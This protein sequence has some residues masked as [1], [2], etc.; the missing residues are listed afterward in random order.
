MQRGRGA[1]GISQVNP[2]NSDA[3][4]LL[5]CSI[6]MESFDDNQHQPK[7]LP[8]HHTFCKIC[9]LN[10]TAQ[11]VVACPTCRERIS[12]PCPPPEGVLRL[13]TNFYITQMKDL[14]SDKSKARVK[15]C[16][17]HQN[18][19]L[20]FFCRSC[21]VVIC[22]EC[23]NTD[24]KESAGH[25]IQHID[26][27]SNE[28]A[29]MLEIEIAE[30]QQS[31]SSNSLNI[32]HL[33]SEIGNLHAAKDASVHDINKA[34]DQYLEVLNQRKRGL[35]DTVRDN[36]T[37]RREA[38]SSRMEELKKQATLLSGLI[39]QCDDAIGSGTISDLL[40]YR[41]KLSSKVRDQQIANLPPSLLNNF[42][43]YEAQDSEYHFVDF[44][45]Q[46][47]GVISNSPLPSTLKIIDPEPVA[48]LFANIGLTVK[49]Y[50]GEELENYPITA[51]ITDIYDDVVPNMVQCR[52]K[53]KFE[54]TFRPKVSGMHRIKIN[55]LGHTIPGG[56]FSMNVFSN[57]PL[58]RI[59]N[60][61]IGDGDLE[62]PR[63]VAVDIRNNIFIADTGNNRI[64]KYDK[65][66]NY[67]ESFPICLDNP[68]IS[69]CGLAIN[70]KQGT[71]ICPEVG[72]KD[73]DLSVANT[74]LV[75][76]FEGHLLQKFVYKDTLRKALSV[77]VNSAG[78]YII[79]DSELN[80]IFIIDRAGRLL[81][82]FGE[83]GSGPGQ[84]C[85]PMFL[86]VGEQ[87]NII[88]SDGDNNRLQVFDKTG[89]FLYTIGSKG[90]G[91]GQFNM[92]FGVTAD[93]HGN[94]LVVDG[95][96]R[97]IQIF[98]YGG[99]FVA[100]I[101]SLADKMN[102]PRGIAVT[103]DGHVLVVDRDNHC[104]KKFKYIHCTSL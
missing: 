10:L 92:P 68:D 84:F 67:V 104:V 4:D 53:G 18:V 51:E 21:E 27:A 3:D 66:G 26:V 75:Y 76:D 14:I 62:Y 7:L 33:E 38:L 15:S 24:H 37:M 55:F 49:S 79:A 74:F 83:Q 86:C 77:A 54:I 46:L 91:K 1:R 19:G 12:L 30:A 56:V 8:C 69:T 64:Q 101:E 78:H 20:E 31:I 103:S 96:N 60:K 58:C 17:K 40:A 44:V 72:V 97:R 50:I 29:R 90:T 82:R 80:S 25:A 85:R 34:F 35:L 16:R 6:C 93:Y 61:G 57:N 63:A 2:P 99:E 94:I 42:L 5:S 100:C 73:A 36:Y 43:K 102:A 13:Q 23:C 70:E 47:G 65:E 98:K 81:K 48:G 71:L 59:G 88:V 95:G 87:D 11:N 28:Q 39:E 41:E 22:R 89:K 52:A 32:R 9:L 45:D